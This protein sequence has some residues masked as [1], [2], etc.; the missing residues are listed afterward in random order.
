[1][2]LA[3]LVVADAA[4]RWPVM[5]APVMVRAV[6]VVMA[7]VGAVVV[8]VAEA[9]VMHAAAT[10][11]ATHSEHPSAVIPMAVAALAVGQVAPDAARGWRGAAVM[12]PVMARAMEP[13]RVM[14]ATAMA[15]DAV[16]GAALAVWGLALALV[17]AKAP[18]MARV[19]ASV[20]AMAV[21]ARVAVMVV[22]V[23]PANLRVAAMVTA[24]SAGAA[25]AKG[26]AVARCGWLRVVMQAL[27]SDVA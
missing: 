21:V 26:V 6:A 25:L 5:A 9:S 16:K 17:A 4:V 10:V 3:A 11:M 8:A 22:V 20:A 12:A 7:L 2:A 24:L 18:V 14:A 19:P 1:M 27:S 23:T 15:L 13:E